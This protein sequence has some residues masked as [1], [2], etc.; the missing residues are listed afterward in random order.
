MIKALSVAVVMSLAAVG[1][2]AQTVAPAVPATDGGIRSQNI[3]EVRPDADLV[4]GYA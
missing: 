2:W 3:F 4:P 1:A